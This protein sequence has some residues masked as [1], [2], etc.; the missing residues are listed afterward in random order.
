MFVLLTPPVRGRCLPHHDPALGFLLFSSSS[1]SF[2]KYNASQNHY[3]HLTFKEGL[4]LNN[5]DLSSQQ[6]SNQRPL[7]QF[8]QG[9]TDIIA[10]THQNAFIP[11]TP[12]QKHI[13][14]CGSDD[15]LTITEN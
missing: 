1:V 5:A 2:F 8:D 13:H 10:E 15:V 14:T 7:A 9:K 12:V 3:D 11:L 4:N 6:L